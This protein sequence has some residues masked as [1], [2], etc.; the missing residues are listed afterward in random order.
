MTLTTTQFHL[1][2]LSVEPNDSPA[3]LRSLPL[4]D[5]EQWSNIVPVKEGERSKF[6]GHVNYKEYN[7]SLGLRVELSTKSLQSGRLRT[8]RSL[9]ATSVHPS[10]RSSPSAEAVP[11]ACEDDT[12]A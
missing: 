4:C 12:N 2:P 8:S 10:W 9:L 1:V 7:A 3:T 5:I 11:R 6:A